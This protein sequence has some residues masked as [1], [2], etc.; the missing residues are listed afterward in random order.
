MRIARVRSRIEAPQAHLP[1]SRRNGN[2]PC[3]RSENRRDARR[4]IR[5]NEWLVIFHNRSAAWLP[6]RKTLSCIGPR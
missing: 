2:I 1:C 6:D 3:D 5:R 4:R